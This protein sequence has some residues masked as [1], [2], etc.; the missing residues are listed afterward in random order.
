VTKIIEKKNDR[1]EKLEAKNKKICERERE[2]KRQ[3]NRQ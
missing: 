3:T 2:K 1:I